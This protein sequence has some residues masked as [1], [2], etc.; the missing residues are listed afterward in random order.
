LAVAGAVA[1]ARLET[2]ARK[3]MAAVA[4]AGAHIQP[5]FILLPIFHQVMLLSVRPVH[6]VPAAPAPV[7]RGATVAAVAQAASLAALHVLVLFILKHSVA[8][9]VQVVTKVTLRLPTAAEVAAQVLSAL[10]VQQLLIPAEQAAVLMVL[11]QEQTQP[12]LPVAVAVLAQQEAP[13]AA[14]PAVM[15]NTAAAEVAVLPRAAQ[16]SAQAEVLSS[17]PAAAA[18]AL[19]LTAVTPLVPPVALVV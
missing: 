19:L 2:A 17:V 18:L 13:V 6:L 16:Q 11:L 8:A 7:Q 15:P 12:V 3:E 1:V 10:A 5:K 4:V 14:L 9:V